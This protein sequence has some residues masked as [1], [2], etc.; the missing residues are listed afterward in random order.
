MSEKTPRL[1]GRKRLHGLPELSIDQDSLESI[2]PVA[3]RSIA[4]LRGLPGER[5]TGQVTTTEPI[6]LSTRSLTTTDRLRC[7][8]YH[9][10]SHS[11]AVPV[12]MLWLAAITE[13]DTI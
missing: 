11:H 4:M 13:I 10:E 12:P 6:T 3:G 9:P 1:S 8:A 2:R 5:Y 7:L